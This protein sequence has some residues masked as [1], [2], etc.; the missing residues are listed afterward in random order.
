MSVE[1][2]GLFGALWRIPRLLA[3]GL[4][5]VYQWTI[6]PLLGARCRFEP[7]CSRY[8]CT[9]IERHGFLRGGWL[10]AKRLSRCH[11]FHP[12]GYDPAPALPSMGSVSSTNSVMST[13]ELEA[14]AAVHPPVSARSGL[15]PA[16]GDPS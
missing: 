2:P 1:T 8:A 4:I 14:S 16:I 15:A 11:P 3:L 12:G 9:C 5:R 7:S 10:S 13:M 6:S